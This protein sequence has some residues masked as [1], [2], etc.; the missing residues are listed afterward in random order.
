MAKGNATE[1]EV[2]KE[3]WYYIKLANTQ[4]SF[5]AHYILTPDGFYSF[6]YEDQVFQL[7]FSTFYINLIV[8]VLT[9]Q[10]YTMETTG[11]W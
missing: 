8:I 11:C 9:S 7:L 5:P 10:I 1:N 6:I 3:L 4:L 2:R